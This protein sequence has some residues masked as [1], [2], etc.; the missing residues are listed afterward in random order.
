MLVAGLGAPSLMQS[1]SF[2]LTKI[3]ADYEKYG[4]NFF[5]VFGDGMKHSLVKE[6]SHVENTK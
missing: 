1:N 6:T 5:K 4:Q 3:S 2:S